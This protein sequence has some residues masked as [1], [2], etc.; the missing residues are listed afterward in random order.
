MRQRAEEMGLT[1]NELLT[2][3]SMVEREARD[4]RE[5]PII[6]DVYLNRW[7]IGMRMEADPTVRYA[8]GKR[9]GEW[10]SAPTADDLYFESP[11]NT[12]QNDGLPPHPICNP[13][14][15]S[16]RAVLIPGGTHYLFFV[17]KA[18]DSGQHWF[19]TNSDDQAWNIAFVK[20]EAETP[21]P[22]SDPFADGVSS[23]VAPSDGGAVVAEATSAD[24]A[25]E[26]SADRGSYEGE[27]VPIVPVGGESG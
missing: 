25:G 12:Y 19:A 6:A 20:G 13:G 9:D 16:I 10:W 14:L 8:I 5:R 17:A 15:D 4:P 3:A 11:F 1:L 24:S 23:R 7:E 2:F 18:D 26:G 27:E 22:G 21:A